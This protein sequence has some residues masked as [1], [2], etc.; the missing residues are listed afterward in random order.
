M[1]LLLECC[2]EIILKFNNF[3][4]HQV[5]IACEVQKPLL[6]HERASHQKFIEVLSQFSGRLPAIVIHCFTGSVSEMSAYVAMGFYIGIC[7][8]ICKGQ[9]L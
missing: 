5:E 2:A 9:W 8:F 6:A 4:L 1:Q 3:L 7:G